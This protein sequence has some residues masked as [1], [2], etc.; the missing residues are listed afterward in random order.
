[1]RSEGV[2]EEEL[3][4]FLDRCVHHRLML[5]NGRSWLG[6]AVHTPAREAAGAESEPELTAVPAG[7][8]A[9]HE[10]G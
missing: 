9:L 2:G 3:R 10:S 8:A 7:A 1:V 5:G 6:L 4:A